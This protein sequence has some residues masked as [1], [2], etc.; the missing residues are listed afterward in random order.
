M[1]KG[2]TIVDEVGCF[3]VFSPVKQIAVLDG[4]EKYGDL[5]SSIRAGL[6]MIEKSAPFKIESHWVSDVG[7]YCSDLR[8]TDGEANQGAF[9]EISDANWDSMKWWGMNPSGFKGSI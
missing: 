9:P 4:S 6:P 1:G 8:K 2:I 3:D 5:S 7:A